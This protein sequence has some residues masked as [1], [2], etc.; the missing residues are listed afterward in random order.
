VKGCRERGTKNDKVDEALLI[1]FKQMRSFNTPIDGELLLAKANSL[2]DDLGTENLSKGWID[3]WK[4]R[5]SIG[6]A[7]IVGEAAS[8]SDDMVKTWRESKL[9]DLTKRYS[10]DNIYNMDETGLFYRLQ[11]D[12]TLHFKG[13]KCSGGKLSKERITLALAANMS[14]T[15]KLTPLVIGKFAKPRCFKNVESLPVEYFHNSKA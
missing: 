7:T 10:P 11:T 5:H 3:R 13:K 4:K 9:P 1:W 15:D 14:G 2:S 6:K 8:V 12:K